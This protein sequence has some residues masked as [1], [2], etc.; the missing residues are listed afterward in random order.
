MHKT[1]I[2]F[3]SGGFYL[4]TKTLLKNKVILIGIR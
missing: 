1:V 3:S 4:F 2:T